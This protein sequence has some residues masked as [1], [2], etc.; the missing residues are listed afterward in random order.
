M[1][2]VVS[3]LTIMNNV[4]AL[5]SSALDTEIVAG[6]EEAL[7]ES[8]RR[9]T[10]AH[11]VMV[12]VRKDIERAFLSGVDAYVDFEPVGF[13]L[14]IDGVSTDL[15]ATSAESTI[16]TVRQALGKFIQCRVLLTPAQVALVEDEMVRCEDRASYAGLKLKGKVLTGSRDAILDLADGIEATLDIDTLSFKAENLAQD[17]RRGGDLSPD[18]FE[19]RTNFIIRSLSTSLKGVLKALRRI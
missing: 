14:V 19:A 12:G 13:A 10:M 6:N 18:A 3:I 7:T 8:S 15:H 11:Q 2:G 17:G 1:V 16:A 5:T 9:V 4:A